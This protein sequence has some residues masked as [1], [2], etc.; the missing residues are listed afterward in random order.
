MLDLLQAVLTDPDRTERNIE[1]DNRL[2]LDVLIDFVLLFHL[3]VVYHQLGDVERQ[4]IEFLKEITLEPP[5]EITLPVDVLE[6]VEI[7]FGMHLSLLVT[8]LDLE[9]VLLQ[10]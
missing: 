4:L 6:L 3:C 5:L 7:S 9:E 2:T 1:V 8:V 10:C